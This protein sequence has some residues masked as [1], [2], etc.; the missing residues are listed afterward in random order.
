MVF[1][2]KLLYQDFNFEEIIYSIKLLIYYLTVGF[3]YAVVL[4]NYFVNTFLNSLS[5]NYYIF[6]DLILSY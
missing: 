3:K 2:S 4:I 6:L 5:S 1:N